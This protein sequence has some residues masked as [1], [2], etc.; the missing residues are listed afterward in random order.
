MKQKCGSRD[1]IASVKCFTCVKCGD[2]DDFETFTVRIKLKGVGQKRRG[3]GACKK[4]VPKNF[5][6]FTKLFPCNNN[7]TFVKV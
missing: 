4:G 1:D 6:I 5:T 2:R 7:V 3:C